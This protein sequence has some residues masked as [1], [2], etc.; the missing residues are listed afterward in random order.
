M[1]HALDQER[2]DI[3]NVAGKVERQYLPRTVANDLVAT[4]QPFGDEATLLRKF[5]FADNVVIGF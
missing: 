1:I 2:V 5:S 4:D 3:R